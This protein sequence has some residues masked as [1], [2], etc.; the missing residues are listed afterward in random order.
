MALANIKQMI[1]A[2]LEGR[3]R[4][5]TWR[6]TPSQVTTAGFWFDLSMSPGNPPPKYW[7]DAPPL[8]AKVVSQSLDGGIYHGANTTPLQQYLR[9]MTSLTAT[10]TALPMPI[11]LLDYLLYYPSCDDSTTD[12]QVMDNTV[13]LPRYTEGKGVQMLAVS[14]AGRTGGQQFFV[15]YTNSDGVAGRTSQTVRQNAASAIGTVQCGSL[16]T[17][18]TSTPFIGLQDGDSGVRSI[19]SVTMV[20]PDVGLF[21]LILVK[22]IAQT[23]IKEITAPYEKDFFLSTGAVP[24]IE[25]DAYL[26]MICLPNGSLAA[27][28]LI[29]DLK[30]IWN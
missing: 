11:Y 23:Q 1:D 30:V 8:I 12:A 4:R 14:V 24:E 25:D 22:P 13:T 16:S 19:D 3:V 5:N 6:K 29:G 21:T 18:A 28:A 20:G 7:F 26:N 2:E 17:A 9:L 10:V 27:T 15:N